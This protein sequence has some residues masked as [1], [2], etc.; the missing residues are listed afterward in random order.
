MGELL[1]VAPLVDALGVAFPRRPEFQEARM[2]ILSLGGKHAEAVTL[3]EGLL[4]EHP[5]YQT[6]RTNLARVYLKAGRRAD[7]VNMMLSA[8]EQAPVRLEDWD[9]LLRALGVGTD[10]PEVILGRI[11]KKAKDSPQVRSLKYVFVVLATRFGRYEKARRILAENPELSDQDDLRRFLGGPRQAE[12]P[13]PP[14]RPR[15]AP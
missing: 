13:R 8:L 5:G 6:I 15:T 14:A 9:L 4:R 11:E 1:E 12:P 2:M 3:G 7:G 10:D